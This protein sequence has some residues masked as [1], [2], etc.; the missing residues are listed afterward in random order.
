[1]LIR[2]AML[3][4]A[5]TLTALSP[6]HATAEHD[7]AK[8][9]YAVVAGGK[10]PNGKLSIAAHGSGEG[11]RD[12]FRVYL[13][14]EPGHRR[15]ATLDDISENNNL[16]TAPDSYHAGWSPDSHY[17]AVSFRSDRHILTLNIYRIEGGRAQLIATPDLFRVMTGHQVDRKTD[18]DMRA[19]GPGVEWLGPRRFRFSEHRL[20]VMQ[21]AGLAD[22]LGA[23][24]K[25]SKM[26]DGRYSVEFSAR[27][28][29]ELVR[30][31][32]FRIG[33]PEPGAFWE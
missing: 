11:G 29:V 9:E 8:D 30:G 6:A 33:K 4:I 12:K 27:A 13:M 17:V 19:F 24:C 23:F 20:F 28:E 3:A 18:G 26:D 14:A 22:R 31:D 15:L 25:S 2:R 10:A 5:L 32:R 21:D 7:Y 1:M 16:D